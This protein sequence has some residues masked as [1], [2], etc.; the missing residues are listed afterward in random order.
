MQTIP[1][2]PEIE[3]AVFVVVGLF[4]IASLLGILISLY[5]HDRKKPEYWVCPVCKG[6]I[7]ETKY[8]FLC[9]NQRCAWFIRKDLLRRDS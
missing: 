1:A 3:S 8:Y 4:F 2:S 7:S 6:R 9:M 5:Q